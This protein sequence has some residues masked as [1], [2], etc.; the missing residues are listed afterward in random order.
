VEGLVLGSRAAGLAKT[1]VEVDELASDAAAELEGE[2]GCALC[3]AKCFVA[4][5]EIATD[6]GSVPIETVEPGQRVRS[7]NDELCT[8]SVDAATCRTVSIEMNDPYGYPDTLVAKYMRDES[9]VRDHHLERGATITVTIDELGI[10]GPARV[11]DIGGCTIEPGTGCL[12]TGT[13]SH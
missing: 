1:A 8:R 13:L 4:G 5:T 12:V 3:K 6:D 9:W 2:E 7:G 11:T 10:S